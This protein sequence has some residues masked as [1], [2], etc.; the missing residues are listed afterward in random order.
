[1]RM[2]LADLKIDPE[3]EKVLPKLENSEYESLD[4]S[5]ASEGFDES[6]PIVIWKDKNIIVDGHNRYKICKFRGVEEVPVI[7]TEFESREKVIAWIYR[8]QLARRNLSGDQYKYYVGKQLE[9]EK[10]ARGGDRKSTQ[11]KSKR[12]NDALIQE[13]DTAERIAKE[14][15]VSRRFVQRAEKF[16][17]GLDAAEEIDP[18]IKDDVLSGKVKAPA[19]IVSKIAT[20]DEEEKE[21]LVN[22][23]RNP[24]KKEKGVN[25]D[26]GATVLMEDQQGTRKCSKC[27]QIKP[28]SFFSINHGCKTFVCKKCDAERKKEA[29]KSKVMPDTLNPNIPV[30]IT[31]DV[32]ISEFEN[33]LANTINSFEI[34]LEINKE[35]ITKDVKSAISK[36]VDEHIEKMESIK[37]GL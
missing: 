33:I 30:V 5:I 21:R 13:G 11:V 19:N 37:K 3:F 1:M 23:I 20:A 18:R 8:T 9:A 28:I 7:E 12:Q 17:K 24:K 31:D 32:T 29:E 36:L 14:H 16:A 27:G 26:V 15:G 10:A 25:K 22:E 6:Y 4:R 2:K 34:A 35:H